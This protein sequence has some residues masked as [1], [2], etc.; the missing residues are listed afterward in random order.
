MRVLVTG[1]AGF[2]GSHVVDA[3]VA[4]GDEVEVL[5]C[6][7]YEYEHDISAFHLLDVDARAA[8]TL[9]AKGSY[10][11]ICHLAADP[12]DGMNAPEITAETHLRG[13]M[14]VCK[15]AA[16]SSKKPRIIFASSAAVYGNAEHVPTPENSGRLP[17][18]PYGMGKVFAEFWGRWCARNYGFSLISLRLA[19]VFGPRQRPDAGVIARWC[20]ALVRRKPI[21]LTGSSAAARDFVFVRDIANVFLGAACC[22]PEALPNSRV[23]IGTGAPRTLR[24]RRGKVAR[25]RGTRS[26]GGRKARGDYTRAPRVLARVWGSVATGLLPLGR[27]R[28]PARRDLRL[29]RGAREMTAVGG[30]PG[31]RVAVVIP[32]WN[33]APWIGEALESVLEQTV[34]DLECVVMDDGSTD[35]TIARA[36]RTLDDRPGAERV[37]IATKPHTGMADTINA[38]VRL[39]SAPYVMYLGADDWIER[40]YLEVCLGALLSR[41]AN[42]AY[43]DVRAVQDSTDLGAAI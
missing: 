3:F 33:V 20:T 13:M 15:G 35:E 26:S 14:G 4:H 34:K 10:D 39:T 12:G 25:S 17:L 27:L 23:N 18:T 19:N 41:R 11:A 8:A 1:G 30:F 21:V 36:E 28:R 2:I 38:G 31:P 29:V 40:A 5:D 7:R 9:I 32:A 42:V 24:G 16:D 22:S 37:T 43:T 6:S